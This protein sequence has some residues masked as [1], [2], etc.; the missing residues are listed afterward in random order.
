MFM[1]LRQHSIQ[2]YAVEETLQAQLDSILSSIFNF[3]SLGAFR[4][5]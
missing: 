5:A 2:T 3:L 1:N 4:L